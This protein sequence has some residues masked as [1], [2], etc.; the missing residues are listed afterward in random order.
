MRILAI[1]DNEDITEMLY[2]LL[3]IDHDITCV[4]DGR[5]GLR[6]IKENTYDLILLDL[7]MPE[8]SGYD[9]IEELEREGLLNKLRIALFT[10]SSMT[11]QE[12]ESLI[13]KGINYCIRKPVALDVLLTIIE[14]LDPNLKNQ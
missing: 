5:E 12:I 2:T 14:S 13:S 10:A 7:A 9:V 8:F 11:E 3:S 6:M 4:N 1:D